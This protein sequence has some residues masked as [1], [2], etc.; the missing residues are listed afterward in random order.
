MKN[1]IFLVI[2]PYKNKIDSRLKRLLPP[3]ISNLI[4]LY[5]TYM[6][7]KYIFI[8]NFGKKHFCN[9]LIL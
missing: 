4:D 3:I 6:G 1:N 7:Y 2:A 8:L 9:V 5:L